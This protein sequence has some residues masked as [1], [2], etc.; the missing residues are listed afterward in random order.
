MEGD[1]QPPYRFLGLVKG[2]SQ[3]VI[4][5]WIA[6]LLFPEF[7]ETA[8]WGVLESCEKV[9]IVVQDNMPPF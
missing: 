5:G 1:G 3:I 7:I 2:K 4:I 6:S 9:K 8:T